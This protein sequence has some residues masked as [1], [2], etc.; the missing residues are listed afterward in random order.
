MGGSPVVFSKLRTK[1]LTSPV[2]TSAAICLT[3][4]D[5]LSRASYSKRA[6]VL[7]RRQ[8]GF[9]LED[10]PEM[11]RGKLRGTRKF[12]QRKSPVQVISHV[13]EGG[14]HSVIHQ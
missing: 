10:A 7:R 14:A 1:W 3:L 12:A 2:P 8:A 13:N 11:D 6:E 9:A 4:N 5:E